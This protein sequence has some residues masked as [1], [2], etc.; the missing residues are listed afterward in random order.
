MSKKSMILIPALALIA[1]LALVVGGEE[2]NGFT[3][4]F[5]CPLSSVLCPLLLAPL[6]VPVVIPIIPLNLFA[7]VEHYS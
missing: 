7:G 5:F 1:S 2:K 4:S 6:I 3:M